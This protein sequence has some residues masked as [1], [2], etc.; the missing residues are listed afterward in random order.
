MKNKIKAL[1]LFSLLI[2]AGTSLFIPH[3]NDLVSSGKQASTSDIVY[4]PI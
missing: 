2:A 4:P 3:S 1:V